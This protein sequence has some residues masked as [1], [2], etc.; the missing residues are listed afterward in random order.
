MFF[1]GSTKELHQLIDKANKINPTIQL[2]MTHTTLPDEDPED[3]CDCV[4]QNAVP[5]LDTL[6]SIKEGQIDVDLYK[7]ETDRNQYLLPSSCH[8]RNV[9]NSIPFSLSLRIVRI[10][11]DPDKRDQ[12]LYELK[13]LLLERGYLESKIDAS[14]DKARHIPRH[15]ALKKVK[16]TNKQKGPVFVM[17]YDPRLPPIGTIQAKHWRSMTSKNKYL[18]EVFKRPPL[19]AYKRQQT[20]RQYVIRAKVQKKQIYEKRNIRGMKKCGQSCTMCP[21]VREG[22]TIKINGIEWKINQNLHCKSY[23]VVYALICKKENCREVYVGEP[24]RFLKFRV[25]DHRGYISNRK[26]NQA[27]GEHF[28][29]PGHSLADLSVTA[30]ERVKRNSILYRKE[31]EEYFIRLFDTYNRGINKK[32]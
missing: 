3:R 16:Q 18:S 30:L 14:I 27:S 26:M 22:K 5:F 6:V 7:K 17:T 20:I 32:T 13:S 28:S 2:T 21:Y 19:I 25:D 31:R 15:K 23:N 10:C 4:E 12:R 11:I 9:T 8:N 29:L 1:V 24:K